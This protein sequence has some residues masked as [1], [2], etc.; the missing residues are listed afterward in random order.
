[1]KLYALD[2]NKRKTIEKQI[3]IDAPEGDCLILIETE[4]G[5]MKKEFGFS[6]LYK[7]N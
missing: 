7:T 2:G 1:M 6:R 5:D 4:F 3:V